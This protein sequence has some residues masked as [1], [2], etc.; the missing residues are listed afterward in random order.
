[1]ILIFPLGPIIL[2]LLFLFLGGIVWV[3][4]NIATIITILGI[5]LA[6]I[7]IFVIVTSV[8]E[9]GV[10]GGALSIVGAIIAVICSCEFFSELQATATTA[11]LEGTFDFLLTL[12]GGGL[13]WIV[14]TTLSWYASLY[15]LEEGSMLASAGILIGAGAVTAI[16]F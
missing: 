9:E 8:K 13:L 16:F 2:V 3:V 14:A 4:E 5:I 10:A 7:F 1:M 12:I 6:I 15:Y 11:S